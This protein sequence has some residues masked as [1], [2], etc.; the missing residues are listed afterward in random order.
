MLPAIVVVALLHAAYY[1]HVV[2]DDSFIS[3]RYATNLVDHGSL[4]FNGPGFDRA[5]GYSNLTWVLL[6][7]AGYAVGIPPLIAAKGLGLLCLA[8]AVVGTA[9]LVDVLSGRRSALRWFGA[10]ALAS[11]GCFVSWSVQALETPLVAALLVW[12]TISFA[13]FLRAP[14]GT[15]ARAAR[16]AG[17]WFGVLGISRPE[18]PLFGVVALAF[19][20]LALRHGTRPRAWSNLAI[21]FA[22]PVLAQLAFRV[23]YYGRPM[24]NTVYAKVHGEHLYEQGARYLLAYAEMKG[25]ALVALVSIAVGV[26]LLRAARRGFSVASA[27]AFV[28]LTLVVYASFITFSGGDYMRGFRFWMHVLPLAS[29]L[30]AWALESAL[31]VAGPWFGVPAR[32]AVAGAMGAL[33][34]RSNALGEREYSFGPQGALADASSGL[35]F[36]GLQG[37]PGSPHATV[38]R[39]LRASLPPRSLVALSEAGIVPFECGLP[40]LDYL[41]LND[42]R[43]ADLVAAGRMDAIAS[44]VLD[45]RPAAIVMTGM[46]S[47][48]APGDSFAGRLP[49]DVA[50]QRDQ[51]FNNYRLATAVPFAA[52]THV[53]FFAFAIFVRNDLPVPG[54]RGT[55]LA[56]PNPVPP[57]SG[58]GTTVISWRTWPSV[59]ARVVLSKDGEGEVLFA[60]GEQGSSTAAWIEAGHS[61]EFRLYDGQRSRLATLQVARAAPA[62]R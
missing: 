34:V 39:W 29:G 13:T 53:P 22:A 25:V 46:A 1:L 10:A 49:E 38:G 40:V 42:G 28:A 57:G 62:A 26:A 7:A 30:G 12:A 51:R 31:D 56:T 17:L 19:G 55:L 52:V 2:Q 24:A 15:A 37:I 44:D 21:A 35:G 9:K 5:E 33:L 43:I 14:P 41:G 59:G 47:G 58:L 6:V 16:V 20:L 45:R 11:S 18:A 23:A 36:F 8:A 48:S 3:F 50:I 54:T 32:V 61:Y 4:T 27:P 60:E